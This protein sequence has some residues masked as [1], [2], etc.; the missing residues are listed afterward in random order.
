MLHFDDP[1]SCEP[2][3]RRPDPCVVVTL[4]GGIELVADAAGGRDQY[5]LGAWDG[6]VNGPEVTGGAVPWETA[7]GGVWGDLRFPG[8]NLQFEGMIVG[9]SANDYA[10]LQA[11]LG[12]VLTNP[13]RGVLRVDEE[14]L[15][16]SRQVEVARGGRPALTQLTD[17][18]GR[19]S[20]QLQSASPLKVGVDAQSVTVT[21]G[22]VSMK[23]IGTADYAP[24]LSLIGPLTNPGLSWPGGAWV[25][26][27]TVPSGTTLYVDMTRRTVRNPATTGH[28]RNLVSGKWLTLPPGDTLVKRTG[29]GS[30]S[31]TASW[32]SAW[33]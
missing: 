16:L 18:I 1:W 4:P 9:R 8:L 17:R 29:S 13:R 26:N 15:G 7:D 2:S 3:W 10:E 6:W 33:H 25:Y 20:V 28:S 12:S 21:T 27:G 24:A 11:E 22:G 30:G 19:Y 5:T 23:N 31:I 32:R 14:H